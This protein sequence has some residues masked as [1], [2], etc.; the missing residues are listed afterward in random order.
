MSGYLY[1][2]SVTLWGKAVLWTEMWSQHYT[3]WG[4][5]AGIWGAARVPGF[6][7]YLLLNL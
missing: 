6:F 2:G 1:G 5:A 7:S 3:R 4:K